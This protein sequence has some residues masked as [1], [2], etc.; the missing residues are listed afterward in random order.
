MIDWLRTLSARFFTRW[1]V[2]PRVSRVR[3]WAWLAA[4][5]DDLREKIRCLQTIVNLFLASELATNRC[6]NMSDEPNGELSAKT[7]PW[8]LMLKRARELQDEG[9]SS[10]QAFQ[11]AWLER[12]IE[13]WPRNWGDDLQILIY[14][15]FEP[16]DSDLHICPLGITIR[17]DKL[18][19]TV[20]ATARCVLKAIVEIPEKSIDAL[21]DATR[22]INILL[23]AWTL[24]SWAKGPA[25]WWSWVT[26]DVGHIG[27]QSLSTEELRRAIDGILG[28]PPSIRRKI[29]AALYWIREPRRLLVESYRNDVLRTYVAYWNAFEC[30]VEVVIEPRPQKKASKSEKQRRINELLAER[31]NTLT[32]GDIQTLYREV[33]DPGFVGKAI[34]AF[35]VCFGDGAEKYTEECF[36]RADK[37]NRLYRIR[38][39]IS[40]GDIDAE[41]LDE[42]IRVESRLLALPLNAL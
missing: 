4:Q 1:H 32:P 26:H 34:Y 10:H 16:P 17:S 41:D 24:V 28:M 7:E 6:P 12:R 31:G 33:V 27:M 18:E 36:R 11:R 38:N 5:T 20:V 19:D 35:Q 21:L 39:A 9:L 2:G 42:L 3:A 14:G 30:L 37:E 40:H 29:E 23:G 15:D 22:R 13:L 25:G 8:D